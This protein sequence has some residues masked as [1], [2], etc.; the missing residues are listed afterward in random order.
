MK[1]ARSV[2]RAPLRSSVARKSEEGI[3]DFMHFAIKFSSN[4]KQIFIFLNK[5]R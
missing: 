1:I 5:E 4:E 2:N 3:V